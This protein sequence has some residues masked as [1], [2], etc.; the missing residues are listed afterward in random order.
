MQQMLDIDDVWRSISVDKSIF[1]DAM[2]PP[3]A[4]IYLPMISRKNMFIYV[5]R[6]TDYKL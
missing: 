2:I 6:K 4:W 3:A 1:M 5:D